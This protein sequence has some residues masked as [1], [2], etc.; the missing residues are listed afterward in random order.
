ME[1]QDGRNQVEVLALSLQEMYLGLDV[2]LALVSF[3]GILA[4]MS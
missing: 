1:R 4:L 2:C 3:V